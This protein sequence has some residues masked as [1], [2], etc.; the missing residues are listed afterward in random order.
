MDHDGTGD[1]LV[2]APFADV[3]GR[4]DAGAVYLYS[5]ASGFLLG[6]L[7][8]QTKDDYFGSS[9]AGAGDV[10]GD[11]LPEVVIGAPGANL[12]GNPSAGALYLLSTADG[13][14]LWRIDG[15][16]EQDGLGSVVSSVDDMDGDRIRDVLASAPGSDPG[17]RANAGTAYVFSAAGAALIWKFDGVSA[18]DELGETGLSDAGDIDGDGVGDVILG[19]GRAD[20]GGLWSAGSAYVYSGAN[21]QLIW[22]FD[23]RAESDWFGA[24]VCGAGDVD[25][26]GANDLAIGAPTSDLVGVYTAG[27]V[28]LFS[29]ATSALIHEFRG[30]TS[31]DELG[32]SV[33]AA[34]DVDADGWPDIIAGAPH[35]HFGSGKN[36]AAYVYHRDPFLHVSSTEWSASAGGSV[37]LDIEFPSHAAAWH[38]RTLFSASGI[39][40]FSYGVEIPLILDGWVLRSAQGVYPSS[41]TTTSLIGTLSASGSAR[42][43]VS[44]APGALLGAV[45]TEPALAVVAIP[46]GGTMPA[47][48]S[49]GIL[50]RIIP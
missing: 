43:T 35:K 11:G 40:S 36:G 14:F 30:A 37:S 21:G 5:G 1:L 24:A 48:A 7:P 6:A 32:T 26:D 13:R 28:W 10:D 45:G 34:G 41:V 25:G 19:A 23:G 42:A 17:G 27:T 49:A 33:A 3:A 12:Q 31:G 2:G 50:V 4:R 46:A 18:G 9:V 38:Y 44:F 29:G 47:A 22:Q 15:L 8:G 20:P 39:G 16:A